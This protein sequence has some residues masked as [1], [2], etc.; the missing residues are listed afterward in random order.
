MASKRTSDLI[1]LC[2]Q[3]N[4]TSVDVAFALE[5]QDEGRPEQGGWVKVSATAECVGGTGVEVRHLVRPRSP[6][7]PRACADLE[8]LSLAFLRW[9]P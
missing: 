2:H 3:I 9:R 1:P 8:R 5:L 4:L 6:S 7:P